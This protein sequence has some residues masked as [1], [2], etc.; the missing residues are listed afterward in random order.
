[1]SPFDII[2]PA[3][4]GAPRGFSH[5]LLARPGARL[6][7]VAGQTATDEQG[8]IAHQDFTEQ[9]DR[10]LGRV[11]AVVEA[12]GGMPAHVG[13]MTIFVTSLER[14]LASREALGR[15]WKDRMGTHYPAIALVEVSRLVDEGAVVEIEATAAI[16]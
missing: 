7:F 5:G 8:R 13:R 15:I 11:L 6:L 16:P 4:L 10:A 14:Y 1:M 9:F 3:A 2:N 12:A